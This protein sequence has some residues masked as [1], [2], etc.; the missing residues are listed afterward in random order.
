[1]TFYVTLIFVEYFDY[2]IKIILEYLGANY[3][4]K[5]WQ[6]LLN[7]VKLLVKFLSSGQ[8]HMSLL[9]LV[10]KFL[11]SPFPTNCSW[12]VKSCSTL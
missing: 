12:T 7:S 6:N 2:N 10:R 3:G 1:M 4:I 11:Y 8:A 9:D 5:V